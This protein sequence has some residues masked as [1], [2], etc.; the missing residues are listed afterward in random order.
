MKPRLLALASV[1]A[2]SAGAVQAQSSVTLYGLVDTGIERLSN[3]GASGDHL[4]RM[5]TL[6]GSFAS[7]WGLRGA[8]DLGAGLKAVFTLE[9]GFGAD[10]GVFQQGN[11][12]FGR[13]AYVGLSGDWGTLSFGRQYSMLL[14]A[15]L[16][17]DFFIAQ[18]YTEGAFDVYLAAPRIDNSISYLGKFRG[19]QF[20]ATYSLGHDSPSPATSA[21][22]PGERAG[23]FKECGEYSAMVRYDTTAWGVGAWLDTRNGRNGAFDTPTATADRSGDIDRHWEVNGY[24][25]L[26]PAKFTVAW[27][28]RQNE[29]ASGNLPVDSR[30]WRVGAAYTLTPAIIFEAQYI[31]YQAQ[32]GPNADN[33]AKDLILRATY[34]F[35]KRTFVYTTASK[36]INHAKAN[37]SPSVATTGT[38]A[39]P[40]AGN[41]QTGVMIGLR[42]SF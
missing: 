23:D 9:S 21:N 1:L 6:A 31:D 41:S 18:I 14:W 39:G 24:Y 17:T 16:P 27:Q 20:G 13:Q 12:L 28:D 40:A 29:L 10:S 2:L 19:F 33:D 30:M 26:G 11:R 25:V 36:I 5:P 37:F 3:V 34:G 38:S 8:E 22:C 32:N 4:Y 15:S 42:H 7:R 35:S